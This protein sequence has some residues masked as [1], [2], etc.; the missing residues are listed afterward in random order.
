MNNMLAV[1][2]HW[3]LHSQRYKQPEHILEELKLSL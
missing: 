1:C 2:Y 3:Q